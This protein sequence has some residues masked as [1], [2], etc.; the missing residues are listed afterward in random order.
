[1]LADK[2]LHVVIETHSDH[3]L[4]G[5]Q[6]YTA[7]NLHTKNNIIIHNFGMDDEKRLRIKSISFDDNL[8]YSEWP[9][10]FMDQTSKNYDEF[11]EIRG[12]QDV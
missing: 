1:M 11:I 3:L 12:S 9:K 6:I 2:G 8:D 7:E 4:D 5:I 10:G